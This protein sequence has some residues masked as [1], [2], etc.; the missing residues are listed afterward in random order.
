MNSNAKYNE[1]PEKKNEDI[2]HVKSEK[3]SE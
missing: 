1:T 2:H 3:R